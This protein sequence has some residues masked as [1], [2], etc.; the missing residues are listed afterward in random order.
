MRIPARLANLA[1]FLVPTLIP[2]CEYT[3]LSEMSVPSAS[4]IGPE[5]VLPKL[6]TM[7]CSLP[8]LLGTMK[9]CGAESMIESG[10]TC[11][12]RSA[13]ASVN[14]LNEEPGWRCALGGEVERELV[15][16]LLPVDDRAADHRPDLPGLV[17]DR[18]QR[19]ARQALAVGELLRDRLLG[20]L[21]EP[22]V[23]RRADLQAAVVGAVFGDVLG[24]TPSPTPIAARI[25]GRS[26]LVKYG[27]AAGSCGLLDH[28]RR[29]KRLG[30]PGLVLLL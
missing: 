8:P 18:H 7:K 1:I 14:G 12:T 4:V 15:V 9:S 11:P 3:V 17:V 22:E 24:G 26:Q 5:Y 2:T 30:D 23:E 29:R 19:R 28:R 20:R 21:L 16:V 10:R 6:W 25:C 13:I 27:A